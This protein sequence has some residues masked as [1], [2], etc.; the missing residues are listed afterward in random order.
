M[1]ASGMSSPHRPDVDLAANC[2]C[3]AVAVTVRG[4]VRAMFL[5]SCEDCQ[6]A[7]GTGHAAAAMVD[8]RDVT[9]EGVTRSYTRPAAS[10]AEFTR[11]FCPTCATPL[12]S[13]TS[14]AQ[15][16]LLLP[17]GLFGAQ[18]DW[19]VPNQLIFSRSHRDWDSIAESLPRHQTYRDEGGTRH[20]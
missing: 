17:V 19:F 3:G 7:S 14:R 15:E 16:I 10:G 13:A 4:R 11:H 6:R 9:V 8:R 5:C 2:A 20:V 1:Q 18:T 12:F